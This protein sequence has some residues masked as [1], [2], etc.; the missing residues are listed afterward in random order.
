M[1]SDSR[2]KEITINASLI[3]DTMS[4]ARQRGIDLDKLLKRCDINPADLETPGQRLPLANTVKLQ[5]LAAQELSDKFGDVPPTGFFR[6]LILSAMH[7]PTLHDAMNRVIEFNNI[8]NRH[9]K[10][11]LSID[12]PY[13][14]ISVTRNA[15]NSVLNDI[16]VDMWMGTIHR[17]ANWFCNELILLN[18]VEFDSPAPA[19]HQEYRYIFY[20]APMKFDCAQCRLTFDKH[21]LNL[22]VVQTEATAEAYLRQLPLDLLLPQ[23]IRGKTSQTIR[24]LLKESFSQQDNVIELQ[25]IAEKM[26]VTTKTI[27]RR[28]AKEGTSFNAIKSQIRRDIA[29]HA[30]GNKD[31]SIEAIAIQTGYSEPSAFI[32]AFK[33]WTGFTPAKFRQGVL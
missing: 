4:A 19:Y 33:T 7:L 13:A 29:M 24:N 6:V 3:A 12:Q 16:A 1:A 20:G 15:D 17:V 32:R 11:T 9:L 14:E 30:L 27:R 8:L 18:Q 31:L 23:D 10:L 22:P 28:L 26:E 21:Y 2:D 25:D 5:R